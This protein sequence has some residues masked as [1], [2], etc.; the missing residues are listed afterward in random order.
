MSHRL[1]TISILYSKDR[2]GFWNFNI[3]KRSVINDDYFA[4]I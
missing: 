3:D 1:W 2:L 4:K